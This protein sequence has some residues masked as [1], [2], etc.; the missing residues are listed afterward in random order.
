MVK[1]WGSIATAMIVTVLASNFVAAEDVP[2]G[3]RP[4][5]GYGG[6]PSF[7][8]LLGAFDGDESGDLAEEEVPGR[9]WGRLSRADADDNGVVTREEF[10][11]V[12]NPRGI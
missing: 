4:R 3:G 9:V 8:T 12:G 1:L 6:R 11:S 2:G 5:G 10:E 7:D